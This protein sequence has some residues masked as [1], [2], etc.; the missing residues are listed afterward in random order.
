V[1]IRLKVTLLFAAV[2]AAVLAGTG[3]FLY[4]RLGADLRAATDNGLRARAE[5]LA[6]AFGEGSANLG[7]GEQLIE[8]DEAFVQVLGPD[9]AVLDSS[10]FLEGRVLLSASALSNL[11]GPTFFDVRVQAPDETLPARLLAVPSGTGAMVVVGSSIEEEQEALASLVG[12]LAIGGPAALAFATGAVWLLAGAAL[13]PVERM[14]AETEAISIS[15]PGRRLPVPEGGDEIARLGASLNRML[16]RLEQALE[17]ERRFVDDASHELR[18][19]VATLK[20]EL[21]LALARARTPEELEAALRG[22]AADADTLARLTEDLLVLARSDRGRLPIRRST[23][24]L[25]EL[26]AQVRA[27]FESLAREGGISL[28]SEVAGSASLDPL[29]LRQVLTNLLHN[30][31]RHTPRGGRV[32]VISRRADGALLINVED[33]GS[34]FPP[35]VLARPFEPFARSASERGRADGGAGLGLAIV[36]AVVAAHA[37][38]VSI[39]NAENGGARVRLFFPEA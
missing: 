13:R 9:G 21:E 39:E 30:A 7:E 31:L 27:G 38:S 18:T 19:P 24:D 34:G 26:V 23:V 32:S 3:T 12:L 28:E 37:G 10:P 29:R 17:R 16:E 11:A 2:M 14:R 20:A 22:A 35:E 8:R 6:A 5:I 33:T 4:L 36:H 15:D 25:A 1:P